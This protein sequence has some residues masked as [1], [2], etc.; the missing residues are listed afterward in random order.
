M[1]VV[2]WEA[3]SLCF[4]FTSEAMLEVQNG[5]VETRWYLSSFAPPYVKVHFYLYYITW[6]KS[7]MS[8]CVVFFHFLSKCLFSRSSILQFL[9]HSIAKTLSLQICLLQTFFVISFSPYS[10]HLI[11]GPQALVYSLL[12]VLTALKVFTGQL[13]P[14]SG[15]LG[16][17]VRS[18]LMKK[19]W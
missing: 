2:A 7:F 6:I 13:T 19:C 8:V 5:E 15:A 10:L 9:L 17:Q 12:R 16:S 4:F 18:E 1:H 14:L 11:A 3:P